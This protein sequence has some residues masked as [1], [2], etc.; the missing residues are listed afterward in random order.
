MPVNIAMSAGWA[1]LYSPTDATNQLAI[2]LLFPQVNKDIIP[3]LSLYIRGA[4]LDKPK[5]KAERKTKRTT[6]KKIRSGSG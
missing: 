6:T 5:K 1:A 3:E 2:R 4:L